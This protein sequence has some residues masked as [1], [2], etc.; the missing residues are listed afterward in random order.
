MNLEGNP[1][2]PNFWYDLLYPHNSKSTKFNKLYF[3]CAPAQIFVVYKTQIAD[4]RN[5][6]FKPALNSYR[7][8]TKIEYLPPFPSPSV[9][10]TSNYRS[11]S[12][13]FYLI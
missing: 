8:Q 4:L 11:H 6:R 10:S 2:Q 12:S 3:I 13:D 9:D 7:S 5:S 1:S